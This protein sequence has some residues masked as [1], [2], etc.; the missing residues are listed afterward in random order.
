MIFSTE[1]ISY[2]VCV[3]NQESKSFLQLS[4]DGAI[5]VVGKVE[6]LH[7]LDAEQAQQNSDGAAL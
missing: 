4:V 1:S 7:A 6:H 5:G 2:R 3:V